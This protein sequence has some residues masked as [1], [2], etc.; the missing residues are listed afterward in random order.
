MRKRCMLSIDTLAPQKT[1]PPCISLLKQGVLRR[2]IDK[3]LCGIYRLSSWTYPSR[4]TLKMLGRTHGQAAEVIT[5]GHKC[6]EWLNILHWLRP[7]GICGTKPVVDY[8]G[9]MSGSV[10]DYKY[11]D[12]DISRKVLSELGLSAFDVSQGQIISRTV[13]ASYL[14][15]W[16]LIASSIEKIAIDIRLLSQS[17]I[18]ELHEKQAAGQ[19]GSSSMPHKRNPVGCENLCGIARVIRGYAATALENIPLWAERDISHSSAERIIFPDG[20]E[21]LGYMLNRMTDIIDKLEINELS[22]YNNWT[23]NITDSQAHLLRLID[24]GMSRKEAH[25]TVRQTWKVS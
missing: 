20:A 13:Y 6:E 11:F 23:K 22:M 24:G 5:F 12:A 25:E 7:L 8:Y 10:G 9:K 16:A 4:E 3:L 15:H 2:K 1:R 19:I 14:Q 21:L 17:G 18:D